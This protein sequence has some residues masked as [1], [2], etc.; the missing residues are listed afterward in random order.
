MCC[1]DKRDDFYFLFA[2]SFNASQSDASNSLNSIFSS[3]FSH[4]FF[5]LW[6]KNFF[7][8]FMAA[9][10]LKLCG[11]T[12]LTITNGIGI[13]IA[14]IWHLW[15]NTWKCL[16]FHIVSVWIL[17]RKNK[18]KVFFFG[19]KIRKFYSSW[20]LSTWL[21]K[22]CER[23]FHFVCLATETD[24][25]CR[26]FNPKTIGLLYNYCTWLKK[27]NIKMVSELRRKRLYWLNLFWKYICYSLEY[28]YRV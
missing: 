7:V 22:F 27:K 23:N 10:L 19:K 2:I 12:K 11:A 24:T 17:Y 26:S 28:V 16:S 14:I 8:D 21:Y 25:V 5:F 15:P 13:R 3:F 4:N 1:E 20:T 9:K 6:E 18:I